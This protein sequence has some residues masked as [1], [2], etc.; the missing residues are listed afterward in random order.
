MFTNFILRFNL[1]TALSPNDPRSNKSGICKQTGKFEAII[2]QTKCL[3]FY[4][5]S[6]QRDPRNH[7]NDLQKKRPPRFQAQLKE[8]SKEKIYPITDLKNNPSKS[9]IGSHLDGMIFLRYAFALF[10]ISI[11]IKENPWRKVAQNRSFNTEKQ[12]NHKRK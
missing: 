10:L 11:G 3:S 4:E 9:E 1:R 6:Q 2:L 7:D 8:K 5:D 12:T